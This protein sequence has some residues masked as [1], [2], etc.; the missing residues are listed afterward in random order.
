M[1]PDALIAAIQEIGLDVGAL[2]FLVSGAAKSFGRRAFREG[3]LY[4][5]YMPV[6][7]THVV[8]WTL[9]PLEVAVAVGLFLNTLWAKWTAL[10]LLAV[11]CGV[12][13]LALRKRLKIPCGCFQ[14]FGNRTMSLQTLR[15]NLL[16]AGVL[17]ATLSLPS[18]EHPWTS[19]PTAGF[20]IVFYVAAQH[21]WQH[22]VLVADLQKQG[23]A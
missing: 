23:V 22:Q 9:P 7:L 14:G 2:V 13:V 17:A 5:P 21:L 15:D 16:L 10:A 11:F 6:S 3:M 20:I 18:R 12:I 1:E 19:I 4:I 8:A